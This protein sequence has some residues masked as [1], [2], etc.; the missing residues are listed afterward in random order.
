MF[1]NWLKT[2]IL[3]AG[4]LVLFAGVGGAIGGAATAH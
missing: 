3:M 2:A 1:G 4:I